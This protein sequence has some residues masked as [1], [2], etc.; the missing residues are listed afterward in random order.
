MQRI[1]PPVVAALALATAL[2]C[3]HTTPVA[4]KLTVAAAPAPA[5]A[6][7]PVTVSAAPAAAAKAVQPAPA[8]REV[9]T[10]A[11][12]GAADAAALDAADAAEPATAPIAGA[13]AAPADEAAV[14]EAP[15]IDA[16]LLAAQPPR[17]SAESGEAGA[18]NILDPWRPYGVGVVSKTAHSVTLA[19][20]TDL[21][22]K[23]IVY[24]G[25]SFGLSWRGYDGVAHENAS[26]KYH[27][28]TIG[29]LSRFRSY[30]FAIVGRGF[31]GTQYDA[32]PI[33]TRTNLF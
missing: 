17:R 29:G 23:A 5:E 10:S 3:A 6:A 4:P 32:Y 18:Q 14:P 1:L 8:A 16:A 33:K 9:V 7:A 28:I 31:L 11:A 22:S 15:M 13:P 24:F 25:K 26:S 21:D 20:R 19:W 30:T 2:G 12:L 27:Q